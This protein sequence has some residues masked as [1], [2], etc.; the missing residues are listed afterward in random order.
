MNIKNPETIN[1]K[2]VVKGNKNFTHL[3][4][5]PKANYTLYGKTK[6]FFDRFKRTYEY[7]SRTGQPYGHI[8][9]PEGIKIRYPK[10]KEIID[11]PY[12]R[13]KDRS[14]YHYTEILY[15]DDTYTS[16][17]HPEIGK[18]V[19]TGYRHTPM[20]EIKS[21]IGTSVYIPDTFKRRMMH[22]YYPK[23]KQTIRTGYRRATGKDI[24]AWEF[25]DVD[26]NKKT[27]IDPRTSEPRTTMK[28][29]QS[30]TANYRRAISNPDIAE[31]NPI[32]RVLESYSGEPKKVWVPKEK[33]KEMKELLKN[34]VSKEEAKR[35]YYQS[36]DDAF[37]N[38]MDDTFS[39]TLNK[40]RFPLVKRSR[41]V[42][43]V[44]EIRPEVDTP[45]L[46]LMQPIRDVEKR[47]GVYLKKSK[48]LGKPKEM[49][50]VY[51]T[52]DRVQLYPETHKGFYDDFFKQTK[53]VVNKDDFDYN[54][55]SMWRPK[56][57]KKFT[58]STKD[59]VIPPRQMDVNYIPTNRKEQ[60]MIK[61]IIEEQPEYLRY[62]T[63][64]KPPITTMSA[65]NEQISIA[66]NMQKADKSF[67]EIFQETIQEPQIL[68]YPRTESP[69][70]PRFS[71]EKL[72]KRTLK[73]SYVPA[74]MIGQSFDS[75]YDTLTKQ[76]RNQ[77]LKQATMLD[78][79]SK[80]RQDILRQQRQMYSPY[81]IQTQIQ[82]LVPMEQQDSQQEQLQDQM[83][84]QQ[85]VLTYPST[86]QQGRLPTRKLP[87]KLPDVKKEEDDTRKQQ[88]SYKYQFGYKEK[89]H[90]VPD[91]SKP[92]YFNIIK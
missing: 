29:T 75:A 25:P 74:V 50:I 70:I 89:K 31:A 90:L 20:K 38:T 81:T 17:Y 1:F 14:R 30:N 18:V 87:F 65:G 68:R 43:D 39:T 80:Q 33:I 45:D 34:Q 6:N 61:K 76:E 4:T 78:Q 46:T 73:T 60:E 42:D 86:Q 48:I 82:S 12:S 47:A 69:Y 62:P 35:F 72:I 21:S 40:D 24:R 28:L 37:S 32:K 52:S 7:R 91:L 64:S 56:P 67:R 63:G 9:S 19:R 77:M 85:Q 10:V 71:P 54:V 26:V 92:G 59:T 16:T 44:F 27:I 66:K 84:Q 79:L 8:Y 88:K 51:G 13:L 23:L 55:S 83:Q 36:F 58:P 11:I 53:Q 3:I 22:E 5:I 57:E 41:Y 15:S 49:K 2:H